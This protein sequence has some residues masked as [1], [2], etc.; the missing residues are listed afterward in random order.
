[1]KAFREYKGKK[2][3]AFLRN[4]DYAHAGEEEAIHLVMDKFGKSKSREIL[5]AACGLGGTA[6][7]I[8]KNGW[9][10]VTG[11]DIEKA[12]INYAKGKYP[13]VDFHVSDACKIGELFQNKFDLICL[14]GSFLCFRNQKASL[15]SLNITA[16]NGATIAISDYLNLS[17]KNES[18]PIYRDDSAQYPFIPVDLKNIEQLLKS[19][20]WQLQETINLTE[21]FELWY[22]KLISKIH[23]QKNAIKK[24]FGED[25]YE[26][27]CRRYD[28]IL[29][30]IIKKEI[31]GVLIYAKKI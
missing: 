16:K 12:S 29:N 18:N 31:G 8:Q 1:M 26:N 9:G 25:A 7:Y 15:S 6:Y 5:D 14:F 10:K 17:E 28:E 23:A 22:T 2:I 19:T 11:F 30:A 4:G 27:A 13:D 3:L 21:K 24:N 20:G